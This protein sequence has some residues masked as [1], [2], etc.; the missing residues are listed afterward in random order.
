MNRYFISLSSIVFMSACSQQPT[1][2]EALIP[3]EERYIP[4]D[5]NVTVP[6]S[7]GNPASRGNKVQPTVIATLVNEADAHSAAGNTDKAIASLERAL[8]I[9]PGNALLWHR[10]ASI[11]LQ[12]SNWQQAIAL[13][14]KSNALANDDVALK[15]KNWSIITRAYEGLGDLQKAR[16]AR[17]QQRLTG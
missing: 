6:A 2:S 11:R 7:S 10:F 1:K 12:Q 17:E 15:S 8:R 9:E 16:E 13:A 5:N 14:R 4:S 3:V